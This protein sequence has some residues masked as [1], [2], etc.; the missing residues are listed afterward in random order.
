MLRR[1]QLF[2]FPALQPYCLLSNRL[3]LLIAFRG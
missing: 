2:Y 1:C 3:L